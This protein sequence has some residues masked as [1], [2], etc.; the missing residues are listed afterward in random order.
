MDK[1][2]IDG[3]ATLSGKISCSGAKNAAL[4][5]LAATLLAEEPVTVRNVPHLK[6]VTTTIALLQT[7]GV[8]ITIDDQLNVQVDAGQVSRME[9]PYELVKTMRASILVLG[10]LVARFGQADVSLPGGCA[11]GARPVN[12]HVAGLQAMGADVTVENGFIKARAK[13]L[14]GAHIVFDVVTVTGTE[15]LLM[16]A[17]LADGETVLELSL[18]HI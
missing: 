8:E 1:L 2:L 12:L 9:A 11:I 6:D 18:I 3:G 4:P 16:A 13:R 15:N 14:Q 7:M 10:P 17:V 5:I